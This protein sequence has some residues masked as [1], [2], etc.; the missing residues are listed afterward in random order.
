M[1]V[2]AWKSGR[3]GYSS[4]VPLKSGLVGGMFPPATKLEAV[5][6]CCDQSAHTVGYPASS[7]PGSE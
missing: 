6:R 5:V 3:K 2:A 1:S 7:P 4:D